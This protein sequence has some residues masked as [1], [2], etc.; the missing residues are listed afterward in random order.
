MIQFPSLVQLKQVQFLVHQSKIPS[1]IELYVY[2]PQ[3]LATS[4]NLLSQHN[5]NISF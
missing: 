1:R 2:A 3:V 5:A 4:A